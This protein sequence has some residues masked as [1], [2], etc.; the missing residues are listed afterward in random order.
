LWT[1]EVN[2]RDFIQAN[3]TPYYGDESFLAGP[4]ER[5]LAVWKI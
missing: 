5:T 2:V 3:Y 4:T 1:K